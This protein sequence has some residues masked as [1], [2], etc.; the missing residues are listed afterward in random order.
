VRDV[1]LGLLLKLVLIERSG[2]S[3]IG[4]L[5]NQQAVLADAFA[6]LADIPDQ[7]DVVGLWRHHAAAAA[8][9]FLAAA[10]GREEGKP[11]PG[12]GPAADR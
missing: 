11:T 8:S 1:R 6:A 10:A 3:P 2:D 12:A 7:P 4:L 5:R 9:A